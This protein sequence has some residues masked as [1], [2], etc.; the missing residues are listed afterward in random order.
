M[1]KMSMNK[2]KLNLEDL[3]FLKIDMCMKDSGETKKEMEEVSKSGRMVQFMKVIGKIT[4]H[5]A[6]EG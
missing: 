3:F 2:M 1:K 5:M 4:K 6:M